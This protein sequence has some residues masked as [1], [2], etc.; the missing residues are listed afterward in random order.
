MARG[1]ASEA[2][3][4]N[5]Q[6]R[7]I[8]ALDLRRAGGSLRAIASQ[9]D[10][11]HEQVRLDIKDALADLK[12][13]EGDSAEELRALELGRMDDLQLAYWQKALK[14]DIGAAY[15]VLKV[16]ESRRKLA[17]I[18]APIKTENTLEVVDPY[19]DWIKKQREERGLASGE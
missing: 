9:L 10:I 2:Q 6:E 15:L 17:G 11:S 4:I 8:K 18:D 13:L 12:G 19:A 5:I 1:K 3:Q 16:S 7:R 14:G